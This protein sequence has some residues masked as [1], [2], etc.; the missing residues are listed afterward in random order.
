MAK[1]HRNE[2]FGEAP[3]PQLEGTPVDEAFAG[4]VSAWADA[5]AD[6]A[7]REGRPK[8]RVKGRGD[9]TLSDRSLPLPQSETGPP[10]PP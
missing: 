5:I 9:P 1:R 10:P 8:R 7:E 4:P 3:Q 2:G 6:E